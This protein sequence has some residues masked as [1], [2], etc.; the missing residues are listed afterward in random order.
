MKTKCECTFVYLVF[1]WR[2]P[3]ILCD[4]ALTLTITNT[5]PS[6]RIGVGQV[7]VTSDTFS[8]DLN[9]DVLLLTVLRVL[10]AVFSQIL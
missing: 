2:L 1:N 3:I 6:L 10:R 5:F 9:L 4:L 8:F 7:T